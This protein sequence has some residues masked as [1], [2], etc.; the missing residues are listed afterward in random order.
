MNKKFKK[1]L[2]YISIVIIILLVAFIIINKYSSKKEEHILKQRDYDTILNN[3][4]FTED[5]IIYKGTKDKEE[6]IYNY[7]LLSIFLST[8]YPNISFY[9]YDYNQDNKKYTFNLYQLNNMVIIDD[10]ILTCSIEAGLL[11]EPKETPKFITDNIKVDEIISIEDVKNKAYKISKDIYG[12]IYLRYNKK[13]NLYYYIENKDN[14]F[15][16]MNA[17]TG[18]I[19][20]SKIKG[21]S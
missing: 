15:V 9:V 11:E 17:F 12:E 21:K 10:T 4:Y 7:K 14:N 5:L 18:E 8:K 19:E 2:I 20:D 16:K 6:L 13:D 3:L 1:I